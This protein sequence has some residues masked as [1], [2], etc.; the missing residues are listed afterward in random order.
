[1]KAPL[2]RKVLLGSSAAGLALFLAGALAWWNGASNH[3]GN[4][5]ALAGLGLLGAAVVMFAGFVVPRDVRLRSRAAEDLHWSEERYRTLFN[6][7]DEG[8]C[9]VGMIFDDQDRPVDYRFLEIN[10]SFENQTGLHDAVGKRMLEL[11]PKHEAHW[12]ET[13]GRIA[14][15]GEPV[16]FQNRAEQLHRWYDVYAFRFGDPRNRQVAILF[17]DIS[18][19]KRAEASL[20]ERTAQL[21]AANGE[22]EAFSYSVSHDLR[23]PLRHIE[24]FGGL[25]E[26]HLGSSLDEKGR[27]QITTIRQSATKMTQL[28]EDLLTFSRFSRMQ[29]SLVDVDPNELV[30]SVIREGRYHADGHAIVWD[31]S[32]LPHV[33]ADSPMLRQVWANLISNA[34]KYSRLSSP[35]RITIDCENPGAAGDILVFRVRDNGVGFDPGQAA[36]LFGVFQRLHDA[37]EFEGTGIGLAN[38]RRIVARHGGRTWAESEVGKGATFYFSIPKRPESGAS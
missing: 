35:P 14:L 23:A 27:H 19:R 17:N 13:Y 7:L 12:F 31:I 3:G 38:V 22:L 37:G 29:L 26:R 30:A 21:E 32:P 25:L 1:V 2:E 16:R 24:G 4:A 36:R 20:L 9:V 15:T 10:P 5:A 11:A 8:F 6:S 33:Q 34:V 18:E 28:I